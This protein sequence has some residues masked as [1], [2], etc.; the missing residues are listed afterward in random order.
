MGIED[1]EKKILDE[2][3]EESSR[4]R[5]EGQR[6]LSGFQKETLARAEALRAQILEEGKLKAEEKKR[7]ILIPARLEAKK[8]ILNQK[9]KFIDQV[10]EEVLKEE[11]VKI[12]YSLDAFKR[13]IKEDLESQITEILFGEEIE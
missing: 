3:R 10:F 5:A 11:I 7:S 9:R 4:I 8:A 6:K 2:A 1:I 13:R 12:D